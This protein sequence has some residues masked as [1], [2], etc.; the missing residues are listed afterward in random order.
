MPR[1]L[2]FSL[3]AFFLALY[4]GSGLHLMEAPQRPMQSREILFE[5]DILQMTGDMTDPAF[6]HY[7]AKVHPLFV[8]FVNPAGA[9]LTKILGGQAMLASISLNAFFGA[10]AA[11]LSFLLFRRMAGG[12]LKPL[13]LALI[14]SFSMSRLFF[15]SVP[16]TYSLGALSLLVTYTLFWIELYERRLPLWLWTLAGIFT[17]GVTITNFVQTFVCFSIARWP[18]EKGAWTDAVRPVAV[19]T[20]LVM[21]CAGAL[22]FLQKALYP[23]TDFFFRRSAVTGEMEYLNWDML[24][25]LPEVGLQL[26]KNFFVVNVVGCLPAV[27]PV[28]SELPRLTFASSWA[29]TAAGYAALALWLFAALAPVQTKVFKKYGRFYAGLALCVLFNLVL[30]SLYYERTVVIEYFI[31]T[32]NFTFGVMAF[33][34]TRWL[35]ERKKYSAWVLGLLLAALAANNLAVFRA[36]AGHYV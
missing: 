13:L 33:F 3:F 11:L 25:Q 32:S 9:A 30:H 36:I 5:A 27:V 29:F 4:I 17:L 21:A 22:S 14:T 2:A 16:E 28:E 12:T 8:L 6:L 20:F 19:W 1:F 35:F 15:S 31:Y 24:R 18:R 34:L 10:L 7:R 26:F 23:S